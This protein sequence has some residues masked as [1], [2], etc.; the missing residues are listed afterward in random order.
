MDDRH[1]EKQKP[2]PVKKPYAKPELVEYGSIEKLTESGSMA[3]G[4]L[5]M[6]MNCL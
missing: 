6:T 1:K 4:D 3:M 5:S 2:Q